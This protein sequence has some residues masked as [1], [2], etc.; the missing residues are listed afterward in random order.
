MKLQICRAHLWS[1]IKWQSGGATSCM[2]TELDAI[3]TSLQA[4]VVDERFTFLTQFNYSA[5]RAY[6]S[7]KLESRAGE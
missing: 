1:S 3:K 7:T 5:P 2:L 6:D 4:E